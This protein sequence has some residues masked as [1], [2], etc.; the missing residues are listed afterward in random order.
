MGWCYL[1]T[2]LRVK[3][4]T[5]LGS[6]KTLKKFCLIGILF[7]AHIKRMEFQFKGCLLGKEIIGIFITIN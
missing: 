7:N 5:I 3:L 6:Y 2:F 4:V 1:I